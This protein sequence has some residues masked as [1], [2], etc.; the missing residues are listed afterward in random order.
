MSVKLRIELE[1]KI[2]RKACKALIEAGYEL[3]LY[4]G[5]EITTPKTKDVK[6]MMDAQA[7]TDE[8]CIFVYNPGEKERIGWVIFTYGND[9]YD[10]ISDYT[11]NLE[12]VLKPVN[13][14]AEK[15]A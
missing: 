9:G 13:D 1:A 15:F 3:R 14:Y 6:V 5:E 2:F 11:T 7:T 10:V 8:D 12:D 4:D